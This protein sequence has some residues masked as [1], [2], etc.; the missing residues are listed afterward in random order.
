M[1]L[2][3]MRAATEG[4]SQNQCGDSVGGATFDTLTQAMQVIECGS[5]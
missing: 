5:L 4:R 2:N 3:W 1:Q